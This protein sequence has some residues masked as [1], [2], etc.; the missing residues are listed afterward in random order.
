[1]GVVEAKKVTLG[2]QNVLTQAERYSRGVENGAFDFD[3][4]RAPFL[5]ST[6]GEV[7]WYHDVRHPLNRSRQVAAFH[8]PSALKEQLGRDFEGA[9]DALAATPN[10][11]KWLRPYQREANEAI[12]QAIRERKRRMLLAMATGTGKTFTTVNEVYRLMK[13]GVAKRVLFLVDRRALAAQAVREFASFDAEPGKKFNQ[14][15]EVYSQGFHKDDLD[16]DKFDWTKLPSAYLTDPPSGAAFVYVCTIQRMAINLFG[17]DKAKFEGEAL[18]QEDADAETLDIPIHAFDLIVADECHR[19][20]TGTE[21][22]VRLKTLEHF[23]ATTIGLTATPAQHTTAFFKEVVYTYD[24]EQAVADSHLVDYNLVAVKSDV[25]INGVFLAEGEQVDQVDT[26]TG[27]RKLDLLEDEREFGAEEIERNV[28]SPDSNKKILL[29]LKRYADEH[30]QEWGR[31][32]KALIFAANDLPHTSHADQL[33]DLARDVFGRGDSFVQKITAKVDRPLQKI[34]EFRNRPEPGIV[35]TVDLLSTGVD[36]RD[37]E[38]IVFLR[39]VKSRILFT[40]ML[41]RGTRLGDQAA[42]KSHFTVFDC[43]DGTLFEYFRNATDIT[44][45]PPDKPG[46]TVHEIIEEIWQN[47]DKDYNIGCLV[48]RLQRIDK[49]QSGEA[50]ELF[51]SHIPNGDVGQFARDL[52]RSLRDSFTETMKLL[53]NPA[54]QELLV[55][56]PRPKR[57]FIIAYDAKDTVSSQVLI[58]DGTGHEYRP[59]DYLSMFARFVRENPAHIQAIEI[60]LKRPS[61][62]STDALNELRAKLGATPERFT[63]DNLRT[64]YRVRYDKALADVISMIKRAADEA[65]PI[66]T[67]EERVKLAVQRVMVGETF[68]DEQQAWLERIQAHLVENLS[69][70]RNDIETLPVFTR[71]GGWRRANDAFEGKLGDLVR[72]L[73][74]A[75]AA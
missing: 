7:I 44:A 34:K 3:G 16:D 28:T 33:V 45:E 57:G 43:F 39:T 13:A 54:L 18:E 26:K 63:E 48:K 55:N 53:R 69:I 73:N 32:P 49:E 25:R 62:W 14:I 47:Q 67:A 6:N 29:E 19:G 61:D 23:D 65:A 10:N 74:E 30:E 56:Y 51:A 41:G 71:A 20:Y 42:D 4:F 5:Y 40:Q 24:Y 50:R 8:T 35:V 12:E 59:E 22:S 17:R 64:A 9:C 60:L 36:I 11:H 37:L 52:R 46:R 27:Q 31:F 68:T 1:M 15:Y 72:K 2:P 21:T 38:F 66:F 75:V 70:D 58:R